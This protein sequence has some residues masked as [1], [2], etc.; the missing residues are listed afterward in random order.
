M[1]KSINLNLCPIYLSRCDHAA[2][3]VKE[4][5]YIFGG[6]ADENRWLNDLHCLNTRTLNWLEVIPVGK[7]APIT[8]RALHTFTAHRDKDLY[9]FGGEEGCKR[10][11]TKLA[12]NNIYK[13]SLCKWRDTE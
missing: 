2:V 9:V 1:D 13:F 5:I 8:A 11:G 12:R 4:N 7:N 3:A 6:C 10:E